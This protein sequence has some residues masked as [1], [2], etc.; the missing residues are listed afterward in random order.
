MGS[1]RDN[2]VS[3]KPRKRRPRSNGE[4]RATIPEVAKAAGVSTATVSRV[5]NDLP[6]AGPAVRKQ[7]LATIRKL[8]YVRSAAG[9][10]LSS[11]RTDTL[12]VV[13]QAL[14][15]GWFLSVFNGILARLSGEYHVLS[16]LST[17]SGDEFELPKLMLGEGRVDGL[18][19]L[20]T[21]ATPAMFEQLRQQPTPF[22]ILQR[23]LADPDINTVSIEHMSGA[24]QAMKHLLHLGHRR[25]LLVTGQNDNED[26]KQKLLGVEQALREAKVKL[27]AGHVIEGHHVGAIAVEALAKFLEQGRKLPD[28]I[29]AFNDDM[30]MAILYWLRSRKVRV[31]EDV[32]LIGF[33]G[34]EEAQRAGLTTVE[35]PMHEMGALAAQTLLDLV[36]S[37]RGSR[38]PKQILLR[39]SLRVRETCGAHLRSKSA[40][41]ST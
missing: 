3:K 13:F 37:P 1:F 38:T 28:A 10:N 18:L 32:A 15:A 24:H 33:D 8:K 31:P 23:Q 16:A 40:A 35:T 25:I 2:H 5:L 7:V 20:D 22:V 36:K 9:R 12:G 17:R 30:A 26:S 6:G 27:P 39:G 14:T 21:R 41:P 19:W 4:K 11:A 34:T 29:F